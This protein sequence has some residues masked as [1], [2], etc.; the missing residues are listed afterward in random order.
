[1]LIQQNEHSSDGLLF[2]EVPNEPVDSRPPVFLSL[3]S[4]GI[5]V[6]HLAFTFSTKQLTVFFFPTA[7]EAPSHHEPHQSQFVRHPWMTCPIG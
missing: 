7:F 6:E 5:A 3:E 4:F 2:F 1:M